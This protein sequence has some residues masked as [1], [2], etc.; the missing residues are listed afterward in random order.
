M[1]FIAGFYHSTN[2]QISLEA[3][4]KRQKKEMASTRKKD[5]S[6]SRYKKDKADIQNIMHTIESQFMKKDLISI[7]SGQVAPSEIKDDILTAHEKGCN[8]SCQFVQQLL[9][10]KQVEFSAPLKTMKMKTFSYL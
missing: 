8:V 7:A 3:A 4:L 9:I 2:E 5:L 10:W 1:L 6:K